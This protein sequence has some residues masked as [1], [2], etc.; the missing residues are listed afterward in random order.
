MI[1]SSTRTAKTLPPPP[2]EES[3]VELFMRAS[4]LRVQATRLAARAEELERIALARI[5]RR[6]Y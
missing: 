3:S 6:D 5:S 2:A 1:E 4:E